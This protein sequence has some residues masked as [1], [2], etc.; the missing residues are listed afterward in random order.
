MQTSDTLIQAFKHL[1]LLPLM[2]MGLLITS[3]CE[4]EQI[5]WEAEEAP[6]QLV[7]E[8]L[9]TNEKNQHRVILSRTADYFSNESTP[10]VS[11]AH[12]TVTSGADT[13]RF[14]EQ[15]NQPG[16]YESP[17]IAGEIGRTYTLDIHLNQPI[18]Q[19]TH[20][21]A[22][23]TMIRGL[24]LDTLQAFIYENPLYVE[25]SPMD[26]LL[27]Y[28]TLFG[29]EPK[30]IDNYYAVRLFK[31]G[32]AVHD[33]IDEVDIYSDSEEFEGDYVNNLFFFAEFLPGD[34]LGIEVSTVS[35]NFR[36]YMNGLQNI[37]NQSGNPFDLSGPPANATGN[38]D[39]GLGYFRVAFITRSQTIVED[40]RLERSSQ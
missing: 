18:N 26:S 1:W 8:G 35:K 6:T 34:S 27:L 14:T 39:G 12:V 11:G 32:E 19:K 2:A 30:E 10:R 13:I 4:D 23:E 29:P 3:G 31:N 33:T 20:Y 21:Q 28:L 5:A 15:Q 7:V 25:E 37:V 38:I 22:T 36:K 40:Q 16:V 24:V 17:P 9:L